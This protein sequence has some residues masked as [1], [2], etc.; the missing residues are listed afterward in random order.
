MCDKPGACVCLN[1]G[2]YKP[3]QSGIDRELLREVT[4]PTQVF[5][6]ARGEMLPRTMLLLL[7][8]QFS[9]RV[10]LME[11]QQQ[12]SARTNGTKPNGSSP[13]CKS[14]SWNH[15]RRQRATAFQCSPTVS[16]SYV[17]V[18]EGQIEVNQSQPSTCINY[19]QDHYKKSAPTLGAR[20]SVLMLAA[21][22]KVAFENSWSGLHG[23]Q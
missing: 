12:G 22:L 3:D 11:H 15:H 4:G 6:I 7:M 1:E 19:S 21:C 8:Q 18:V 20:K 14:K 16:T 9:K 17:Q 5:K 10:R 23:H 13:W 2:A